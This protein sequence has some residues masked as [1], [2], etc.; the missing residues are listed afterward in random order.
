[1]LFLLLALG[2]S[3]GD[4]RGDLHRLIC[5]HLNQLGFEGNA[6]FSQRESEVERNRGFLVFYLVQM[7]HRFVSARERRTIDLRVESAH[8][9]L[10][11]LSFKRPK[12]VTLAAA[13]RRSHR[14]SCEVDVRSS[15]IV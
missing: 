3:G 11:P 15:A 4:V 2:G 5:V 14:V 9:N 6:Q 10:P 12:R 7:P 1:M 8:R 13:A